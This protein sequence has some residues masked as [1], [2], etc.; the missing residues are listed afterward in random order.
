MTEALHAGDAGPTVIFVHGVGSTAAIWKYQLGE[1]SDTY[2]CYAV[3]L[4]GNGARKP[5]AAP[6]G[7][8]RA[9]FVDDVL[10]V[11]DA[12]GAARFHFV[13]CSLGGAVGF[14]LWQCAPERVKSFTFVGCYAAYPNAHEYV[15]GVEG[16][17]NA[18]KSMGAFARDRAAKL[19]LPPAREAETIAQMAGKS[20]ESY[21]ATT[22]ATWTGD[23]RET[24]ASITVPAL[25]I[26][27]ERDRIAP[28]ELSR[29]IADGI[30]N[31]RLE[32]LKDAGHVGNAD[33]PAAFNGLLREFLGVQPL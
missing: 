20:R 4:S 7:I 28:L 26:C 29:E 25:V 24:L 13:G 30:P 32:I 27:G 6:S 22:R 19:G 17:V 1:L 5:E 16:A 10:A 12:A 33:N 23:Y 15:R 9:A 11:A 21:L 18:A 14:E 3:E 2:R 31:A 8:S